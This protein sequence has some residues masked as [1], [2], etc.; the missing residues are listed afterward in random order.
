MVVSRGKRPKQAT[1]CSLKAYEQ[2]DSGAPNGR[3][4]YI[5][6]HFQPP[7]A[8]KTTSGGTNSK[9]E[10]RLM[11]YGSP[12]ISVHAVS[13]WL[14]IWLEI[15]QPGLITTNNSYVIINAN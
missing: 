1:E 9:L 14:Q 6:Y 15:L 11:D 13:A 3:G 2:P 4:S 8:S 10:A 12:S 7:G 5:E